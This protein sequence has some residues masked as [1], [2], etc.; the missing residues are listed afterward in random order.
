MKKILILTLSILLAYPIM[1]QVKVTFTQRTSI[2]TP[3]QKI[4]NIKG[5]FQMIGNT[6]LTLKTYGDNTNNSNNEM[7]YVD[8]CL[9]SQRC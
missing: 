8:K 7:I 9:V 1:A 6:N 3:N 4:Y 5:D 2:Y